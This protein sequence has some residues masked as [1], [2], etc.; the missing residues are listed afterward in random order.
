MTG[1][2]IWAAKGRTK[3]TVGQFFDALGD[4]RAAEL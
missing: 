4:E 1:Q 3:A 2:V